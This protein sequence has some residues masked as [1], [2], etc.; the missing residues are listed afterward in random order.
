[1]ATSPGL[2]TIDP[3]AGLVNYINDIK[4]YH[5][6]VF[7]V[8][9]QYVYQDY[10][11][12][13]IKDSLNLGLNISQDDN[14]A[15]TITEA[16]ITEMFDFFVSAPAP[17]SGLIFNVNP[18]NPVTNT[19]ANQIAFVYPT[20]FVASVS[21]TTLDV[22]AINAGTIT[23]GQIL[24]GPG[25]TSGT[26]IT[27]FVSGTKGGVG[28]YT[29]SISQNVASTTL[30]AASPTSLIY[31]NSVLVVNGIFYNIGAVSYSTNGSSYTFTL[32]TVPA[33]Y[34]SSFSTGKVYLG[35]TTRNFSYKIT[36]FNTGVTVT[37]PVTG[38]TFTGS[39]FVVP[40]FVTEN[41]TTYSQ[42]V[43]LAIQP[44]SI[45]KLKE[46][47]DNYYAQYV[48][49]TPAFNADGSR[50]P[51]ADSTIIGVSTSDTNF[52]VTTQPVAGDHI[53]PYFTTGY[54]NPYD[55]RYDQMAGYQPISSA[56]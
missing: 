52:P 40:S 23:I 19:G 30:G 55:G 35:F 8:L 46:T 47:G 39:T 36:S 33:V 32:N 3:I 56:P 21:G 1:M 11:N 45:F 50:N 48:H 27:G 25:V 7:E 13:T 16:S 9:V 29:V 2:K 22:T 14:I 49:F 24:T 44:G 28:T 34:P 38:T 51:G 12:V 31:P 5:S 53:I 6:K 10:V 17:L 18:F 26:T 54:D 4:P 37:E 43:L 15:T 41:N 20:D 42:D